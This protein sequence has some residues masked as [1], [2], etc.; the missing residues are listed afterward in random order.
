MQPSNIIIHNATA[1]E[2]SLISTTGTY[3]VTFNFSD[4][5][6]NLLDGVNVSIIVN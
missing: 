1:S 3:S 2:L 4:I 5:A 6:H